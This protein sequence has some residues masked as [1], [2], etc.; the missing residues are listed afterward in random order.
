MN[1]KYYKYLIKSTVKTSIY[2]FEVI[3]ESNWCSS[4]EYIDSDGFSNESKGNGVVLATIEATEE[5]IISKFL[6]H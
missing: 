5:E 3:Q 2:N 4:D 1:N 6:N